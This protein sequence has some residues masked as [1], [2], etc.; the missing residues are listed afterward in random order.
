MKPTV[1]LIGVGDLAG[2]V[3]EPLART[4]WVDRIVAEALSEGVRT[5]FAETGTPVIVQGVG[6]M[7]QIMFTDRPAVRDYREFCGTVNRGRFR[8][9]VAEMFKYRVYMSPSAAL[10]SVA[11]LAHDDGDV[12]HTVEGVRG[13]LA[14]AAG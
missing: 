7:F 3:L 12:E 11:T 13:A 6:P 5:L 1:T 8:G 2:C 9:F 4:D 10:H 14:H